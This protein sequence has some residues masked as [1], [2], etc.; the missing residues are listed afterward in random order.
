MCLVLGQHMGIYRNPAKEATSGPYEVEQGLGVGYNILGYI[1]AGSP[2]LC[3]FFTTDA[4]PNFQLRSN[5]L[6]HLVNSLPKAGH[7]FRET[8]LETSQGIIAA[9]IQATI[10]DPQPM[11]SELRF[12]LLGHRLFR[13]NG[14]ISA[15][16]TPP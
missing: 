3:R 12:R 9:S 4:V 7:T 5:H 1:C 6:H 11:T 10:S 2:V 13:A 15:K 16:L 8:Q 14:V